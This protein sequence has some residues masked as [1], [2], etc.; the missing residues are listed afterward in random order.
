MDQTT[1]FGPF[2]KMVIKD[3]CNVPYLIR[4]AINTPIGGIKLHHILRSD[5][6]RALH[7]HPWN[8]TSIILWGGYWEH[9]AFDLTKGASG[10]RI[11]RHA[12][13]CA[14]TKANGTL[15]LRCWFRVG[16]ILHRKAECAHR[17]EL[18]KGK[19]AWTLVFTSNKIRDWGF[20]TVKGWI[21]WRT[22]NDGKEC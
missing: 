20:H 2:K 7:D 18:P 5:N 22:Y 14:P 3:E 11:P 1:A 17:V 15:T 21:P 8:F 19:T 12:Q 9:V 6:D 10:M 4:Y 16:S 13:F